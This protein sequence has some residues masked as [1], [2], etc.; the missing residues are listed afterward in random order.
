MLQVADQL[1]ILGT[2]SLAVAVGLHGKDRDL[3]NKIGYTGSTLLLIGGLGD[4]WKLC[5][6]LVNFIR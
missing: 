6:E 1:S 5:T 2:I 3:A 4:C